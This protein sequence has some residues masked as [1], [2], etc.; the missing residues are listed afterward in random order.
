MSELEAYRE[1]RMAQFDKAYEQLRQE[2]VDDLAKKYRE[3][4]I[5]IKFTYK[6]T[7]VATLRGEIVGADAFTE[8]LV[9]GDEKAI[10]SAFAA[11]IAA[12]VAM[13]NQN[14]AQAEDE[15]E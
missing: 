3:A 6:H 11:L 10:G 14:T 1:E 13:R 8:S 9:E 2:L 12:F 4:G 5:P 15:I 7:G